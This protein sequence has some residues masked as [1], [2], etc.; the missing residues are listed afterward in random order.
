MSAALS[1]LH[2][3]TALGWP[4]TCTFA[5]AFQLERSYCG[6]CII[7]QPEGCNLS[8]SAPFELVKRM[9]SP[10]SICI[11]R[12]VYIYT[13]K[14]NSSSSVSVPFT[15]THTAAQT[16]T[17]TLMHTVPACVCVFLV[18]ICVVCFGATVFVRVQAYTYVC[19]PAYPYTHADTGT[20]RLLASPSH[21]PATTRHGHCIVATHT[22]AA[23]ATCS[24]YPSRRLRHTY[25]HTHTRTSHGRL[26]KANQRAALQGWPAEER[27]LRGRFSMERVAT[28]VSSLRSLPLHSST[29]ALGLN[30]KISGSCV[31][32][33]GHVRGSD[34]PVTPSA[35]R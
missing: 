13:S 20:A 24:H 30:C 14:S 5:A 10:N 21:P 17:C 28:A 23:T 19:T 15:I 25:T 6:A 18:C 8:V 27:P 9:Y 32:L 22:S 31:G 16:R 3:L 34:H 29:S 26:C 7:D 11:N 35:H 12:K 4:H 1:H 33:V 2:F